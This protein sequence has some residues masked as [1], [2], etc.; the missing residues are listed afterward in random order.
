MS[1]PVASGF[2]AETQYTG[3]RLALL[4]ILQ[5]CLFWFLSL[6]D[7]YFMVLCSQFFLSLYGIFCNLMKKY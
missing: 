6:F 7:I 1:L 4:F 5:A 2:A 3:V